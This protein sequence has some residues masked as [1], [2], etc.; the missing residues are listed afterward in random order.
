[1]FFVVKKNQIILT[2]LLLLLVAAAFVV[3]AAG[4]S[5][6]EDMCRRYLSSLGYCPKELTEREAISLP[7]VFDETLE[8][9][10]ALQKDAGFD[11][12]PYR[13]KTLTRMSFTLEDDPSLIA[14]LFLSGEAICGGDI[15]NPALDGYMLPLLARE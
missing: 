11:F 9:Y 6:E 3:S 5:G 1:M 13:G 2:L 7:S 15:C 12:S 8:G 10:N 4:G 14:H